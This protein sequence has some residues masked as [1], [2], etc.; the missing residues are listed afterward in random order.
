MPFPYLYSYS[1]ISEQQTPT[2][3]KTFVRY[4]EVSAIGRFF[5]KSCQIW[6]KGF[7]PQFKMSAIWD[8]HY[9]EVS[10]CNK[11][12]KFFWKNCFFCLNLS[13]LIS[14]VLQK[15]IFFVYWVVCESLIA[16]SSHS[17]LK[18]DTL[19]YP[20]KG[21]ISSFYFCLVFIFNK[22]EPQNYQFFYLNLWRHKH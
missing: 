1:E 16:W 11:S 21:R 4:W 10:M 5:S 6:D 13:L 7:C 22:K 12:L 9:W 17:F 19:L 15:D 18:M 8:V 14:I 3:F 20:L 2:G